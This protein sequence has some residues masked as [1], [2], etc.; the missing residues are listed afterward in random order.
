MSHPKKKWGQHFLRN[1]AAVE[2]IAAAVE[3]QDGEII[4]EIGPG[5]GVLTGDLIALG[6]PVV[7]LEIDPDLAANLRKRFGDKIEVRN[8]DAVEAAWSPITW[9]S[10]AA[11][12]A[13]PLGPAPRRIM[14]NSSAP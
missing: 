8:E 13:A 14:A 7:A 2:K 3:P 10:F 5:E 12:T 6:A 9:R 4:L 11:T 1:H